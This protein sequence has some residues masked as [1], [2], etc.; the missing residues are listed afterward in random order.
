MNS[1]PQH[2]RFLLPG[3]LL[4]IFGCWLR[5]R[6]AVNT[7]TSAVLRH[8]WSKNFPGNPCSPIF[9]CHVPGAALTAPAWNG[10]L[11]G[12]L[13]IDVA[14]QLNMN[15]NTF[16]VSG[17]GFRG[18][19]G[20]ILG[21]AGPGTLATDYLT[22]ATAAANGSKGEGIAGTPRYIANFA[23]TGLRTRRRRIPKWKVRAWRTG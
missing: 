23:Q 15:S 14:S 21:G 22:L 12:V 16:D 2:A 10:T 9:E 19:A 18:G 8:Q 5:Q 1:S 20:R 6:G 17:L 3:G 4:Y 11:G 13:A 7:Y